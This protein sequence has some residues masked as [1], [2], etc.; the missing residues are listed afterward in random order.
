MLRKK[1]QIKE[2]YLV[3][4]KDLF[5]FPNLSLGKNSSISAAV[6]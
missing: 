4:G 2:K 3:C 5:I 6:K 1:T